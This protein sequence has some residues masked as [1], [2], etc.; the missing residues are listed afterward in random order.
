MA[1]VVRKIVSHRMNVL[2]LF[3]SDWK[4]PR[5]GEPGGLYGGPLTINMNF[6][7]SISGEFDCV[8]YLRTE[9][10]KYYLHTQPFGF[11]D[12]KMPTEALTNTMTR[13]ELQPNPVHFWG[14]FD[15]LTG[16]S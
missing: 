2:A 1:N 10:G 14:E 3:W 7:K 6:S 9:G 16:R 4:E 13:V 12:A 8:F 11:W 15:K 5:S